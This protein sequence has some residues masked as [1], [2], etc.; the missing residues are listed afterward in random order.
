[1]LFVGI[2]MNDGGFEF[3][4]DFAD[5]A[6]ADGFADDG[7]GL[8]KAVITDEKW[9]FEGAIGFYGY[10]LA[11]DD[12]AVLGVEHGGGFYGGA[13][14]DVDVFLGEQVDAGIEMAQDLGFVNQVPVMV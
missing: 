4:A 1:M 3:T 12:G 6:D 13:G 7:S 5:G 14:A 2:A 9:A 11:D 10:V 8:D